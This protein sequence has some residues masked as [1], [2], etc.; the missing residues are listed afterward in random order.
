MER[1]QKWFELLAGVSH[2]EHA[3][4]ARAHQIFAAAGPDLA[5]LELPACWRRRAQYRR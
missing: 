4:L 5:V 3:R 2:E 1:L